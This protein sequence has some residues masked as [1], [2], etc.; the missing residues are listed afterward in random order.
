MKIKLITLYLILGTLGSLAQA[1]IKITNYT[2]ND[3]DKIVTHGGTN[4]NINHSDEHTLEVY[5][6]EECSES[7]EISVISKVLYIEINDPKERTCTCKITIGVP[8]LHELV[9]NGGG[10]IVIAKGFKSTNSFECRIKGGGNIDLSEISVDSI[11]AS[12]EGGGKILVNARK[13]LEG[14]VV[15]GGLIEY[16]GDPIV[17]PYISGGGSIRKQ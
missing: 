11:Y 16:V 14:K 13:I 4:L 8:L 15:G 5:T 1:D 9:Q 6:S 3:F 2:I 12:I 10:S 7:V 17:K